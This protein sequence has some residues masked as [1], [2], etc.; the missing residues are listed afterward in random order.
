MTA[1][2]IETAQQAH[3]LT[4][5]GCDNGQGWHFGRPVPPDEITA[6]IVALQHR[7]AVPPGPELPVIPVQRR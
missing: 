4:A 6:G 5:A 1:E 2:G 3:R 7:E